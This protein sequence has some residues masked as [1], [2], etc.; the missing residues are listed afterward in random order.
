MNRDK[1]SKS[2]ERKWEQELIDDYY[3]HR[4]REILE[5][6]Y[7]KFQLW[8]AGELEHADM[9]RA[10]HE[11]HK[12]TQQVYGSFTYNRGMLVNMIQWDRAWF[13]AWLKDHEPPPGVEL[14]PYGPPEGEEEAE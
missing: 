12:Q 14:V 6:F 3:D 9:D 7:E 2:S 10:I 5:P 4:W 8:D 1:H 13:E 11:T